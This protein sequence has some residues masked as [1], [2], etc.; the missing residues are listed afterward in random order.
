MSASWLAGGAILVVV[1]WVALRRFPRRE[2]WLP[3]ELARM[4]HKP[5]DPA[6]L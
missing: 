3:K 5:S 2:I 1:I 6:E 4:F